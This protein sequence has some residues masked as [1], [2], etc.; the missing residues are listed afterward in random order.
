MSMSSSDQTGERDNPFYGNVRP[1]L[2]E[3]LHGL[4]PRLVVRVVRPGE[5]HGARHNALG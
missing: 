1:L 5:A 2:G 4:E 3:V